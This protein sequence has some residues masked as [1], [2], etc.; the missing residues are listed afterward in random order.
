M[1]PLEPLV[2]YAVRPQP[3]QYW[4]MGSRRGSL[5]I[6]EEDAGSSRF[7]VLTSLGVKAVRKAANQGLWKKP[8]NSTD[9]A[10][11]EFRFAGATSSSRLREFLKRWK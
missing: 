9:R 10:T 4:R 11:T 3:G 6:E 1:T 8:T 2:V 5:T 7:T